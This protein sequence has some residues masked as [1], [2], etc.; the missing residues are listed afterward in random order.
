MVNNDTTTDIEENNDN[1]HNNMPTDIM[2]END[3]AT[4]STMTNEITSLTGTGNNQV[5]PLADIDEEDDRNEEDDQNDAI[6]CLEEDTETPMNISHDKNN[7]E[8]E[9]QNTAPM[10][11]ENIADKTMDDKMDAK[12]G[13]RSTRWNLRQQKQRT[14]KHH[15]DEHAKNLCNTINGGYIGDATNADSSRTQ[16]VRVTR[17]QRS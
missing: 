7:Q 12:Y 15:Y 11:M 5:I 1:P 3:A 14:Y 13:T 6:H 2:H 17:G 9:Q 8:D 16:T 4:V 10:P